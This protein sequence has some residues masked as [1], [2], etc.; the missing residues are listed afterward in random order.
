MEHPGYFTSHYSKI[1]PRSVNK[2]K[3][4]ENEN[5]NLNISISLPLGKENSVFEL[6]RCSPW[7]TFPSLLLH[8]PLWQS[9]SQAE[10]GNWLWPESR[11]LFGLLLCS[12]AVPAMSSAHC[13][14]VPG[15]TRMRRATG[16]GFG[17]LHWGSRLLPL[18]IDLRTRTTP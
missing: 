13:F 12:L 16:L 4:E 6:N 18:Q 9:T 1:L 11:E 8:S 5:R 3:G 15:R 17:S 14:E 7:Q 10:Q 2:R